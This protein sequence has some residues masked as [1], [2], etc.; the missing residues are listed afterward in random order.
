LKIPSFLDYACN[1]ESEHLNKEKELYNGFSMFSKR[2]LLDKI[3][4]DSEMAH[5][6]FL[7]E[8]NKIEKSLQLII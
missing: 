6:N 5:M 8:L 7:R 4:L 2:D 1:C 3:S